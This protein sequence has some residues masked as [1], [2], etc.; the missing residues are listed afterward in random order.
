V[1]SYAVGMSQK[2]DPKEPKAPTPPD[3]SPADE[4]DR[5][6]EGL[7]ETFPASDPPAVRPGEGPAG[8]ADRRSE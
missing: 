5:L 2:A 8:G 7:E 6:D 3:A 1:G 4:D